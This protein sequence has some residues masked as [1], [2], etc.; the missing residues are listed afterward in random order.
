MYLDLFTLIYVP[1]LCHL[2]YVPFSSELK[3][4][5]LHSPSPPPP[6]TE[7]E[8]NPDHDILRL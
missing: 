5:H 2:I 3:G 1:W 7:T 8:K 4:R 6:L